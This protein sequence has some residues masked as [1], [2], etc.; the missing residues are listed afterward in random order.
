MVQGLGLSVSQSHR[1]IWHA[2]T[3]LAL[4]ILPEDTLGRGPRSPCHCL[5][6]HTAQL[7]GDALQQRNKDQ[8]R[9]C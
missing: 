6:K 9:V 3:E 4:P 1:I 5:R 7:K 2:D 8:Q